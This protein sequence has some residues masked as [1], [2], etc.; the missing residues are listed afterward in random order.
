MAGA[1][2]K[3]YSEVWKV[4]HLEAALDADALAI[5]RLVVPTAS[6]RVR[7]EGSLPRSGGLYRVTNRRLFLAVRG[8]SE[9][10]HKRTK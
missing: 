4:L 9:I 10:A 3:S 6:L 5:E 7:L 8:N 1:A 2:V